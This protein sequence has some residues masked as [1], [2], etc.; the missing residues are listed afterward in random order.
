MLAFKT[1]DLAVGQQS[2]AY[3]T[4]PAHS[5]TSISASAMRFLSRS[6]SQTLSTSQPTNLQHADI[7]ERDPVELR[8]ELSDYLLEPLLPPSRVT[9]LP[10]QGPSVSWCDPLRYW[11]AHIFPFFVSRVLTVNTLQGAE[12]RFPYLFRLAMDILPAQASSVPCERIFSSG[13]GTCT[14]HRNRI[15]PEL[16]EALQTLKFAFRF[17]DLDLTK[18]VDDPLSLDDENCI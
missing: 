16:M 3:T 8:S 5:L 1:A 12:K 13:K 4:A 14:P 6:G 9:N 17:T 11:K 2:C 7:S 18:S 15:N 10:D